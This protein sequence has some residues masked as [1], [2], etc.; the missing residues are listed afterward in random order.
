LQLVDVPGV[1][2][3]NCK[4]G[5]NTTIFGL[6]IAVKVGKNLKSDLSTLAY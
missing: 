2:Q 6:F 3:K 1:K 5:T 4:E